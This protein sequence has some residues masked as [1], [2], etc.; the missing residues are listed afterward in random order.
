MARRNR[1]SGPP[2]DQAGGSEGPSGEFDRDLEHF[3]Q[4][5][6]DCKDP[7]PEDFLGGLDE[8]R[9]KRLLNALLLR[10]L[11]LERDLFPRCS[12]F[13]K[14][15]KAGRTP[16]IEDHLDCGK[17]RRRVLRELLALE[18]FWAPRQGRRLSPAI[19]RH[20]FPGDLDVVA[21]AFSRTFRPQSWR[22]RPVG[23]IGSGAFGRISEVEDEEFGKRAALKEVREDKAK[24][25]THQLRLEEEARITAMLEHPGVVPV[26]ARGRNE[27]G[28][29]F[30]V[31]ELVRGRDFTALIGKFHR[32]NNPSRR[33][34]R[35]RLLRQKGRFRA[36]LPRPDDYDVTSRPLR[37]LLGIFGRLCPLAKRHSPRP[38]AQ[39][40]PDRRLR[41]GHGHGLG[42]RRGPRST[43]GRPRQHRRSSRVVFLP[44]R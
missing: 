6:W 33:D 37:R 39:E 30:F 38:E 35:H 42:P 4:L 32:P 2:S 9:A 1:M 28:Q 29:P 11:S 15:L 12:L 21:E 36:F 25:A 22:F 13:E 27:K 40:Y 41:R 16:A 18:F 43:H 24:L 44:T 8:E 5:W 31:M 7:D 26:Y 34:R 20:R 10:R 17:S 14:A 23:P 19:Y 3:E